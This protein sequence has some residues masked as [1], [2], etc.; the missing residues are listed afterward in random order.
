MGA[1]D[2][3][4][5]AVDDGFRRRRRLAFRHKD[6]PWP[7]DIVD[8]HHQDHAFGTRLGEDVAVEAREGVIAHAVA[9]H[10]GARDALV[11]H[12]DP[13]VGLVQPLRQE[14]RPTMVGV[15]RR[16]V[17]IRDRVAERHDRPRVRCR[18]DDDLGQEHPRFRRLRRLERSLTRVI[19]LLRDVGRLHAV[20][21]PGRDGRN[22]GKV[23]ADGDAAERRDGEFHGVAHDGRP[24]RNGD[25]RLAAEGELVIG[26]WVDAPVLLGDRDA[27]GADGKRLFPVLVGEHDPQPVA[28]KAHPRDL[29]H[30][31]IAQGAR[32]VDG[33]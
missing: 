5:V 29:P 7:A 1:G 15:R 11:D 32:H 10:A 9:Q 30:R 3:L 2:E 31:L 33:R 25:R 24:G 21:V 13:R 17:A 23:K 19:T 12:G 28:A 6:R 4:L 8:P 18:I 20:I 14:V 22:L 26:A 27:R 16:V